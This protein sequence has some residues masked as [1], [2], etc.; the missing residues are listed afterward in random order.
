RRRSERALRVEDRIRP[1]LDGTVPSDQI[2]YFDPQHQSFGFLQARSDGIARLRAQLPVDRRRTHP[3]VQQP[4]HT[5]WCWGGHDQHQGQRCRLGLQLGG[6][7]SAYS[8]NEVGGS[9]RSSIKYHITGP[10]TFTNTPLPAGNASLDLKMPDTFSLALNHRIDAKWSLLGDLTRT[11][12]SKIKELNI[13]F[14]NGLPASITP[15]NFRNTW[16]V[17]VGA[18]HRYD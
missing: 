7:L 1:G 16:R 11:G 8:G 12:W 10:L 9:Y 6:H 13:T 18:V 4:H 14:D 17:G 15:E 5:R 2:G 3:C